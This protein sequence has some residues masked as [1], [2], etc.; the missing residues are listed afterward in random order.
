MHACAIGSTFFL[1]TTRRGAK[2]SFLGLSESVLKNKSLNY[3]NE[4]KNKS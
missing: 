1:I 3:E 4:V 2:E